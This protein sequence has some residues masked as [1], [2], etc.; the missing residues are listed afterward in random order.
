MRAAPKKPA[1]E[2]ALRRRLASLA[3]ELGGTLW[4]LGWPA[5]AQLALALVLAELGHYTFH[6]ISH[7]WSWVWPL[8]APHHSAP[9]LCWLNATRFNILDLFCL[10]SFQALAVDRARRG[11]RGISVVHGRRR[12]LR[13]AA[14]WQNRAAH[15]AARLDLQ[16]ARAAPLAS[17]S[18]CAREQS[19]L[20]RDPE[21]LD[22][23]FASLW[24][25]RDREFSGP[26]GIA[27][28]PRFSAGYLG[29]QLAPFRWARIRRENAAANAGAAR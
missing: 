26:V 9:R 18:R 4:P 28:L 15:G 11:S 10:L 19:Q 16:H 23:L 27:A 21:L 29:Q 3:R 24:R 25:P 17:L 5:L 2:D 12:R 20:R 8:H 6:R 7:E 1:Q 14:T 13:A 22:L